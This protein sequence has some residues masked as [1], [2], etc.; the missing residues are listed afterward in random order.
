MAPVVT[1]ALSWGASGGW[2]YAK[3]PTPPHPATPNAAAVGG[4]D[5]I[6][7]CGIIGSWRGGLKY[8]N[9]QRISVVS[10]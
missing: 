10:Y 1:T 7:F 4:Y 3:P 5:I 6:G 9:V 8:R 2:M